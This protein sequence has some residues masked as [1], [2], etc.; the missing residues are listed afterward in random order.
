M[1]IHKKSQLT[2][3][4]GKK[5][6]LTQR[7]KFFFPFF[8]LHLCTIT[9]STT[10]SVINSIHAKLQLL[11]ILVLKYP[12]VSYSGIKGLSAFDRR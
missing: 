11:F 3:N 10:A 7:Y 5:K 9:A 2:K 8:S 4:E 1:Q 6:N 12:L